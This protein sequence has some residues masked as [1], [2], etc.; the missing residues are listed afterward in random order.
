MIG[1][2]SDGKYERPS[3]PP[4]VARRLAGSRLAR[5]WGR[6]LLPPLALAVA[7]L[8]IAGGAAT[9][10]YV[11]IGGGWLGVVGAAIVGVSIIGN[12]IVL[13]RQ[14]FHIGFDIGVQA[15]IVAA[16]TPTNGERDDDR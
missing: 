3:H 16:R 8:F 10:T 2:G 1:G 13:F 15:A 11:A 12:G 5:W 14:G 9:E 4:S 6:H 7:L